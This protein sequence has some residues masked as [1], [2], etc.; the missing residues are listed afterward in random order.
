MVLAMLV[1]T[2]LLATAAGATVTATRD[3]P[4]L[5]GAMDVTSGA[6]RQHAA[7]PV[8]RRGRQLRGL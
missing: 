1:A 7:D 5:A 6:R 2:G 4:A 8:H 3:A